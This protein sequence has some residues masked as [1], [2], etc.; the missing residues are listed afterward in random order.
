MAKRSAFNGISSYL[1]H[2]YAVPRLKSNILSDVDVNTVMKEY[3][4][5]TDQKVYD[6][7]RK[8]AQIIQKDFKK[9][10]SYCKNHL[11]SK[12]NDKPRFYT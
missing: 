5:K 8:N 10:A 1:F 11:K 4:T 3:L 6:C 7:A 12:Q 2:N 9:F